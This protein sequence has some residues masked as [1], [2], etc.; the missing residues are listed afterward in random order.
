MNDYLLCPMFLKRLFVVYL[1]LQVSVALI[2]RNVTGDPLDVLIFQCS[3][4]PESF[5]SILEGWGE[6][7]LSFYHAHYFPD[8]FLPIAYAL[9]LRG[10]IF[11]LRGKTRLMLLPVIAGISDQVENVIHFTLTLNHALIFTPLFYVGMVAVYLKWF[12]ALLSV[13]LIGK[14]YLVSLKT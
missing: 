1:L 5:K 13:G 9:L 3:I 4:A 2:L 12:T 7:G 10:L 8:F 6:R 14:A 11:Q